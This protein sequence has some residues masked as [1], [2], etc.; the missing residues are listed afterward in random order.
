MTTGRIYDL[1]SDTV[2]KPSRAMRDAMANAEVGDDMSG[3]D[4]TVNKLE[5]AV[6][7]KVRQRGGRLRVFGD[8]VQP[9][10]GPRAIAGRVTNS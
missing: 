4:P 5:S 9:D 10:G 6:R 1:R 2:T 3:E 7:R 8:A